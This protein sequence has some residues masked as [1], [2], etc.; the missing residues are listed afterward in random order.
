MCGPLVVY[1]S[2]FRQW[3]HSRKLLQTSANLLFV[4]STNQCWGSVTF[5]YGSGS[6][7]LSLCPKDP[8]PVIFVRDLQDAN[9]KLFVFAQFFCFLLFEGTL[10]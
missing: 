4:Q 5:W 8:D 10:T 6:A 3:P 7:D 1:H 9:K 2:H